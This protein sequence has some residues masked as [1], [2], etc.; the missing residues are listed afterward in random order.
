MVRTGA[1]FLYCARKL[2]LLQRTILTVMRVHV[3]QEPPSATIE[4]PG[5]FSGFKAGVSTRPVGT[6]VVDHT[7]PKV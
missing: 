5:D 6:I 7:E 3:N 2:G 1:R 4:K